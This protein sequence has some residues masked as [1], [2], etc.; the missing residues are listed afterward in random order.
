MGRKRKEGKGRKEVSPGNRVV[1]IK[2]TI[3]LKHTYTHKK[4]KITPIYF[5]AS[6]K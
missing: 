3:N 4:N 2:I 6:E 1:G 5:M